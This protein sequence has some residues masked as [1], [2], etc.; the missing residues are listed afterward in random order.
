MAVLWLKGHRPA[1]PE[2]TAERLDELAGKIKPI[3][4][5]DGVLHHVHPASLTKS[6][7]I[8]DPV[9]GK[10]VKED[11]WE[12]ARIETYHS[13][14]YIALFKPSVEEVLAQ[15]P[16]HLTKEVDYFQLLTE[17]TVACFSQGDGHRTI[18]IL[19]T[20]AE[21]GTEAWMERMCRR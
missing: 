10:R 14:G 20:R 11:I 18:A 6:S 5:K 15:I 7:F 3:M 12:H 16:E 17:D 8:W 13:C 9:W 19:Y 2:I 4:N 1:I 21:P